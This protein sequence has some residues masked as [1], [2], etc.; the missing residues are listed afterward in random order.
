M[1]ETKSNV[2]KLRFPGFTE[3]WEQRK[4]GDLFVERTE[5]S[6]NL[7]ILSVS[8]VDGV[9]PASEADRDSNPGASLANYKVVCKGDVVYNSM[10]M[11]QGALDTSR[12]NGIVSPA[13]VVA[14]PRWSYCSTFF[15]RLLKRPSML[16]Q[17]RRLSQGNSKD[18]LVL[19]YEQFA[20]ISV[21]VPPSAE[22]L[23]AIASCFDLLDSFITLHQRKLEHVKLLKR[24][25]LQK[26]LPKDG[27]DVPEI[28][29]PGFTDS[30]EQRKLGE[31]VKIV[32][33][34]TP[35]TKNP[36]YWEGEINWFTP[37]ELGEKIFVD[38]SARKI[39]R[40]GYDA[41]SANMLPAG[42]TILFTSRAGIGT[43]AILR[44]SAC[45]NQG[46]QSFVVH[47]DTDVNFI[48]AMIPAIKRWACVHASGSTFLEISGKALASMSICA[49]CLSEQKMIGSVF[50]DF[51][52]LITL[53]QRKLEHVKLLKKALLQQMFV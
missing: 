22:E 46:F 47:D 43:A 3:P 5:R 41:C 1:K 15:S 53:H 31:L 44:S 48:F 36:N 7:E 34:G 45:T 29:F 2:P 32:S 16:Y 6:S 27:S 18:T 19:K 12:F 50:S 38:E 21:L 9:F 26:M 52:T 30:W 20:K 51:D 25:L 49:P 37:A 14:R 23:G 42:K 13:Y 35:D 33:G 40:A 24:G 17:Y 28:R 4:L 39:T 10:R 11:W 8:V